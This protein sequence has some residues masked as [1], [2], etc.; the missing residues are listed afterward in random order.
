MLK[1]YG[2]VPFPEIAKEIFIYFL[3]FDCLIEKCLRESNINK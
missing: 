1:D 3:I 2:C